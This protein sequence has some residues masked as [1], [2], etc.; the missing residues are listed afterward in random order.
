MLDTK[1]I[2][3]QS[4]L[5]PSKNLRHVSKKWHVFLDCTTFM[6]LKADDTFSSCMIGLVKLL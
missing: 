3:Y 4:T 6:M 5:T 2:L 1:P